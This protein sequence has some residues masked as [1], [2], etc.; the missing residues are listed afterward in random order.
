M[1]LLG[2][3]SESGAAASQSLSLNGFLLSEINLDFLSAGS[4]Y[5]E[6]GKLKGDDSALCV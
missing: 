3:N 1:Q 4:K 6:S 5:K 2:A